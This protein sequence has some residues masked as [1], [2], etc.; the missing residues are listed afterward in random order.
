MADNEAIARYNIAFIGFM[1]S[2]K[3]TI[4]KAISAHL[5]REFIDVDKSIERKMNMTIAEIFSLNGEEY[6]RE[7][8][9]EAVKDVSRLSCKI[10][11]YG[12]GVCLDPENI[13]NIKEKSKV[14]LLKAS[15]ETV[16]MRTSRNNNR[17]LLKGKKELDEIKTMMESRL[18][19]YLQAADIII[20]TEGKG[21]VEIRD[22]VL[23]RLDLE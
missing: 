11:S 3:T 20:E 22:E 17:P 18:Y 7:I 21:I 10:I 6:F 2:G 14:I 19:S 15:P 16:L 9:K 12:G 4:A 23:K 13:I 5:D 1:A 8:E